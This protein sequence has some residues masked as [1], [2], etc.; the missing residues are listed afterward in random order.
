MKILS[1]LVALAALGGVVWAVAAIAGQNI[2]I[3]VAPDEAAAGGSA[4][5]ARE[6]AA[7][8]RELEKVDRATPL[9]PR[10][11]LAPPSA[12]LAVVDRG[13]RMAIAVPAVPLGRP[14]TIRFQLRG[15]SARR[16]ALTLVRRDARYLQRPAARRE[17]GGD[18]AADVRLAK[19][20]V[21]R[22]I[23]EVDGGRRVLGA[24]L[25]VAGKFE[26]MPLPAPASSTEVDGYVAQV[27]GR[28]AT[29]RLTVSKRGKAVPAVAAGPLVALRDGD[30]AY[31]S[32]R[33]RGSRLRYRVTYPGAGVYR[34]F[35]PFED[36]GR[37]HVAAVTRTGG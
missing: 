14:H 27:R 19:A 36:A 6:R 1:R 31:A 35:V 23:A 24:D 8:A 17:A 5:A 30:L 25:F 12:G 15:G 9:R 26:P 10:A 29:V 18:W 22:L 3:K 7:R 16:V 32:A 2:G 28:G 37:V 21:Y 33:P 11:R 4:S 20:G 13:M 34:L